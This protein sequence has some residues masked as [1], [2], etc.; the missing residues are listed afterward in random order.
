MV[1][2]RIRLSMNYEWSFLLGDI[3]KTELI[4]HNDIYNG[5]K[6]GA[7]KGPPASSYNAREWKILNVPHDYMIEQD[8]DKNGAADW[9]Y[10]PKNNAWYRKS[11]FIDKAHQ[12]NKIVLEF[13]GIA[14]ESTI[15]FNGSIIKRNF[16]GYNSFSVDITDRCFFDVPNILAVYING[17][18]FEGWW[19]EGQGIY[20]NVWL[21]VLPPIHFIEEPYINCIKTSETD[22]TVNVTGAISGDVAGKNV[23]V[24]KKILDY[25][26]N[27][28]ADFNEQSAIIKEPLIWDIKTPT[29]YK[30]VTEIY[31]DD[32]KY[33]GFTS[34]FGFRTIEIR[35]DKLFYLNGKKIKIKG[36]CNHQDFAGIGVAIPDSIWEYKISRLKAMGCNS[37]RSSHGM[38]ADGL[39]KACDKLGMLLMDENRNFE[40]SD[41]CL[42]QLKTMVKRDRNHPSVVFYS[43]FNEEPL[44][45][46][47]QGRNMALR[48]LKEIRKLDNT[49]FIT[50]AMHGGI[51]EESGVSS[52]LDMAGINYQANDYKRFHEKY[53]DVAAIATETT[54]AFQTRGCTVTDNDLHRF[55]CYDSDPSDWG[56]TVRDTWKAVDENEFIIGAY[57]WTGFD[58]LGEPTP[59]TFPSVSSFFGM[60][61]TCGFE[62]GGFYLS[63]ALW[64]EKPYVSIL[65]SWNFNDGDTVKVM[66]CT[67]CE[68]AELFING[69]SVSREKIDKYKQHIWDA[70]FEA[71]ALKLVGYNAGTEVKSCTLKTAGQL[72]KIVLTPAFDAFT[73]NITAIPVKIS[74]VDE[75]GTVIPFADNKLNITIS[76]GKILGT[77]NGDPNCH[78]NFSKAKR[79]L[80]NGLAIAV[81]APN[82]DMKNVMLK[83]SVDGLEKVRLTIPVNITG[84]I[85]YVP[86]VKEIY[87]TDWRMSKVS[88]EK[89]D[90]KV[91]VADSDMNTWISVN[92]ENGAQPEFTEQ[93]GKYALYRTSIDIPD[94]INGHAP[95]L[96]FEQIL[97]NGEVYINGVKVCD[98]AHE[99]A[100]ALDVAVSGENADITVLIECQNKY[101]AGI[102]S[103]IAIR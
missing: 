64:S 47:S 27:V 41:E 19:Y 83:V 95:V 4:T 52:C 97:G 45:S 71:G 53:P 51:L 49:R 10:R 13:E 18:A 40:T 7:K 29:L 39:V 35:S 73:D 68:E 103:F 1:N 88:D 72:A 33:D 37:Y 2:E 63:K 84:S 24:K 56:N 87:L 69:K 102:C 3:E 85:E 44:Q 76:G 91:I 75:N 8:V 23:V 15:Y 22:W 31:V 99:W 78:D 80:F 65:P 38:A 21:N 9:G 82:K 55:S 89:P 98:F 79:T 59:H 92:T 77:A 90:P 26:D 16:S 58:Y 25:L 32:V 5:A 100:A 14:T 6:A 48:M 94:E 74:A 81:I 62:K 36:T 28:V 54:S 67:N 66:T 101:G 96:H 93:I 86:T 60:M 11:F 43:I 34:S 50:G 70:P 57:M 61:D 12:G 42:E 17:E 20:R 30:L 46:T